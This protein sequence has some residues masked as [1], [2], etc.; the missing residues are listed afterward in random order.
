M[1]ECICYIYGFFE[2]LELMLQQF[3]YVILVCVYVVL[4]EWIVLGELIQLLLVVVFVKYCVLLDED[5][6][7]LCIC[8]LVV[9][10]IFGLSGEEG[11]VKV[12]VVMMFGEVVMVGIEWIILGFFVVVVL[13]VRV[14]GLILLG[15]VLLVLLVG[16][17][18]VLLYVQ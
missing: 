13:L 10:S 15:L 2:E 11:C 5:M 7:M 3:D 12:L 14:F 18:L 16:G 6:V 8:K 9:F 1:E 17:W 4:L